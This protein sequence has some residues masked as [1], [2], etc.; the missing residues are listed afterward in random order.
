MAMLPTVVMLPELIF[1]K[2]TPEVVT[3][4]SDES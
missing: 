3:S 4:S 2:I 1:G